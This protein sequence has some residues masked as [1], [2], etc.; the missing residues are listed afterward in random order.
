M[1]TQNDVISPLS[2][3]APFPG[4]QT[5]ALFWSQITSYLT[6]ILAIQHSESQ[7]LTQEA[8]SDS[9]SNHSESEAERVTIK[10]PTNVEN[11]QS[12]DELVK[13]SSGADSDQGE[14]EGTDEEEEDE[15]GRI[16]VDRENSGSKSPP[17]PAPRRSIRKEEAGKERENG[18]V[19]SDADREKLYV[20]E[21]QMGGLLSPPKTTGFQLVADAP[22]KFAFGKIKRQ[23][24][25]SHPYQFRIK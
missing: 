15:L 23:R 20:L 18:R 13:E 5:L 17:V 21:L 3:A 9:E 24:K 10:H 11:Q 7:S 16:E 6:H 12:A 25:S 4:R 14:V 2:L 19:E 1:M 8:R 22:Y